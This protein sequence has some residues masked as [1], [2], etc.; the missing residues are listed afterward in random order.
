V[1]A[2]L[3]RDLVEAAEREGV[4]LNQFCSVAL[5]RSIGYPPPKREADRPAPVQVPALV[6]EKPTEYEAH[7]QRD[8]MSDE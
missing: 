3:H 1:P 4:S 7:D 8:V 2:S 6:A 5:A